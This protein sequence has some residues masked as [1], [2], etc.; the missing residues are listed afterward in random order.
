MS[1]NGIEHEEYSADLRTMAKGTGL[2]LAGKI[3]RQLILVVSALVTTRLLGDGP[4]GLLDV[5][6]GVV[7]ILVLILGLGYPAA[8]AR[9]VAVYDGQGKE[10]YARG[11]VAG[12]FV[13]STLLGIVVALLL[14]FRPDWV[15]MGIY[16]KP[17]MTSILWIV[18]LMLPLSLA[19]TILCQATIARRTM[20]Y[21]ALIDVVPRPLGIIGIVILCGVLHYGAEG[22]ALAGV[23]AAAASLAISAYGAARHFPGLTLGDLRYYQFGE[24]QLLAFPLLFAEF[25]NFGMSQVNK[26]IGLGWLP[27]TDMGKYGA[28]NRVAMLGT[29]GLNSIAS[30]F[31][32]IIA[33]LHD[34]GKMPEL[35]EMF[36]TV[37]RWLYHMTLPVMLLAFVKAE[38]V[39]AAFGPRFA[40][41]A[42]ALRLLCLGQVIN[43]SVGSAGTVLAMSGHQWLVAMNNGIAAALNIVVCIILTRNY[44]LFGLALST[45]ITTALVNLLR[46]AEAWHLHR[47]SAYTRK[48]LKPLLACL[49]TCPILLIHLEPWWLD[50]AV[51]ALGFAVAYPVAVLLLGLEADDREVLAAL[52]KK[53]LRGSRA[54]RP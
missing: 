40:G 54:G 11:V 2:G 44:G 22:A 24:V 36:Q 35:R 6:N 46:A 31:R 17:A 21:Q 19:G 27:E 26:L 18:M 30:I 38:S 37:T 41:G 14:G 29:F 49:I 42:V 15:S 13:T 4:Y 8:V 16:N 43:V 7:E 34:R 50:L 45:A 9:Y 10:Q 39:M 51:A 53:L 48:V 12:T 47:I 32:P 3:G 1:D 20:L 25:S 5:S 33:E 23:G 52:K 28:A